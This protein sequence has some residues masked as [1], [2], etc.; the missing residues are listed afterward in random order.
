MRTFQDVVL[1]FDPANDIFV[2]VDPLRLHE[3][4]PTGNASSFIDL[5]GLLWK[6]TGHILI[7]PR[8]TKL[9]VSKIEYQAY[10]K[11]SCLG[12]YLL[13]SQLIHSGSYDGQSLYTS[14]YR[15]ISNRYHSIKLENPIKD[16]SDTLSLCAPKMQPIKQQEFMNA[17]ELVEGLSSKRPKRKI[18]P[19]EYRNILKCCEE[20]GQ[21]GERYVY[22]YERKWLVKHRKPNLALKVKW[23]SQA[24]VGEGYDILSFDQ[25]GVSK[26]IE[27]KSSKSNKYSF[28]MS[29]NEWQTAI[30]YKDKYWVYRILGVPSDPVIFK[31]LCNPVAL[32]RD[33]LIR[34][35]PDGYIVKIR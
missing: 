23:V 10:I 27:V 33:G 18:T 11:P 12:D 1:G 3:G 35:T 2:G 28:Q 8:A 5:D 6:N 15:K 34:R 24:S 16:N 17:E 29:E 31:K 22:D 26:Y 7:R 13:N 4:G 19:I 25:S 20:H 21:I 32:E 30:K 14:K 9:Q